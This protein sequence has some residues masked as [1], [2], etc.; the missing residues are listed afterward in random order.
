M[1]ARIALGVKCS[2]TLMSAHFSNNPGVTAPVKAFI[3]VKIKAV[4]PQSKSKITTE[5]IEQDQNLHETLIHQLDS[6]EGR[7]ESLA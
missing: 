3:Q 7:E 5:L 2:G 4:P 6:Y 1:L